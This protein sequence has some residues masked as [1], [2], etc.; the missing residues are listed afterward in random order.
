V[1]ARERSAE[2]DA[3]FVVRFAPRIRQFSPWLPAC[4]AGIHRFARVREVPQRRT[5]HAISCDQDSRR[6]FA[7]VPRVRGPFMTDDHEGFRSKL[8]KAAV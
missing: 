3:E 2:L 6:F 4:S 8:L 7:G 1:T 5:T